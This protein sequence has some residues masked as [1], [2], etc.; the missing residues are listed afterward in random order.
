[1]F[2]T[3]QVRNL[4]KCNYFDK[5]LSWVLNPPCESPPL[6]KT[7][8][9]FPAHIP[10]G[11]CC[12]SFPGCPTILDCLL[13]YEWLLG[14]ITCGGF[15]LVSPDSMICFFYIPLEIKQFCGTVP[16]WVHKLVPNGSR[17]LCW[18]SLASLIQLLPEG[19][20]GSNI[21][22]LEISWPSCARTN[23]WPALRSKWNCNCFQSYFAI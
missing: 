4:I 15:V 10:G 9:A 17:M 19:K 13:E 12:P 6:V 21:R 23:G 20:T 16:A 7:P 11:T 2:R 8:I 22:D 14:R 18:F 1:M 5:Q 3:L